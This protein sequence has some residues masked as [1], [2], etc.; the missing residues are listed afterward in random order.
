M[1][2]S[3]PEIIRSHPRVID[4]FMIALLEGTR[5]VAA[6]LFA[7]FFLT[8]SLAAQQSDFNEP[9]LNGCRWCPSGA[10][11][12]II[13]H[14]A[15]GYGVSDP[16]LQQIIQNAVSDWQVDLTEMFEGMFNFQ[17]DGNLGDA[18]ATCTDGQYPPPLIRLIFRRGAYDMGVHTCHPEETVRPPYPAGSPQD[19]NPSHKRKG[20]QPCSSDLKPSDPQL[21]FWSAPYRRPLE[22]SSMAEVHTVYIDINDQIEGFDLQGLM[23]HE[24]GHALGLGHVRMAGTDLL[25]S[26]EGLTCQNPAHPGIDDHAKSALRKLYGFATGNKQHGLN[27]SDSPSGHGL[28]LRNIGYTGTWNCPQGSARMGKSTDS[29]N[30]YDYELQVQRASGTYVTFAFLHEE[31]WLNNE[32][33]HYFGELWPSANVRMNV[34]DNGALVD[35]AQSLYRIDILESDFGVAPDAV[36][37]MIG[38]TGGPFNDTCLTYTLKNN[39]A[40]SLN[41]TA[42]VDQSWLGAQPSSGALAAG[43]STQV[44]VCLNAAAFSLPADSFIAKITFADAADGI[45]VIRQAKLVVNQCQAEMSYAPVSFSFNV[46]LAG[47][48]SELLSINNEST[49]CQ[50]LDYAIDAHIDGGAGPVLDIEGNNSRA[51]YGNSR[52]RGNV[53]EVSQRTTLKQIESYLNFTGSR[54]LN[55]VVFEASVLGGPYTQ[56]F[57]K[58][59]AK[60]GTGASF[61]SSGPLCIP[62]AQSKFYIVAVGWTGGN[63][64]FYWNVTTIPHAMSFGQKHYGFYY[65]AYPIGLS[66]TSPGYTT[67]DYYQ[68]LTTEDTWLLPSLLSGSITPGSSQ[69][70]TVIV[71]SANRAEGVYTGDLELQSTDPDH[72]IAT[73]PVVMKVG[74]PTDVENEHG[75]QTLSLSLRAAYPNPFNPRV[76]I[77]YS[78]PEQDVALLSI[79]DVSG[80]LVRTLIDEHMASGDHAEIWDGRDDS[81]REVTTGVYLVRLK[82]GGKMQSRK[83]MLLR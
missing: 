49:A 18:Q 36:G 68:R 78:I 6:A 47:T 12:T 50:N 74:N 41:W 63:I 80:R 16:G 33:T 82:S 26:D 60:T 59:I 43:G 39:T 28:Q 9:D 8:A 38:V 81:G 32:Y 30:L 29:E 21:G 69:T 14:Y 67:S 75:S 71:N 54:Q 37:E 31:D 15:F 70:V 66:I 76:T 5:I 83:I 27:V 3:K 52:Y 61:Y 79:Y 46:E 56:L 72:L 65:D 22:S 48:A 58:T 13:I 42:S 4:G 7:L 25:M 17:C 45:S 44:N 51:N 64:T 20:W 73:I 53:Y 55:F 2:G 34:L 62:M 10:D 57:S 1:A 23:R 35:R 77:L 11:N 19:T 40:V 24:I